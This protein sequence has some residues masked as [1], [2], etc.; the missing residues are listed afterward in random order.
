MC[1]LNARNQSLWADRSGVATIEYALIVSL[2]VLTLFAGLSNLGAKV[3]QNFEQVNSEV[4]SGVDF[5]A[6]V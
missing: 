5:N 4:S 6:G 3:G 2:I 1:N